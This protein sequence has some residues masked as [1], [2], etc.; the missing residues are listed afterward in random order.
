M[1]ELKRTAFSP[2]E[3]DAA[4]AELLQQHYQEQLSTG[5]LLKTLRRTFFGL[6][7]DK[8]AKLV[9]I[10]RRTLVLIEND[11]FDGVAF[12]S[13]QRA[14]RPLGM[15]SYIAPLPDRQTLRHLLQEK[16]Q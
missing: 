11:N 4:L 7:Q 3:R 2:Q 12:Q 5:K 10:S 1:P 8:Y 15:K 14:F 6:T 9:K 16:T 13:I